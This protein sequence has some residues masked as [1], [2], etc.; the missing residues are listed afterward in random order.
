MLFKIVNRMLNI[1]H[2]YSVNT[3]EQNF[4]IANIMVDHA[5]LDRRR[6]SNFWDITVVFWDITVA[7]WDITVVFWDI[8]VVFW[9]ITGKSVC[10]VAFCMLYLLYSF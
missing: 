4:K 5:E 7:F 6:R 10:H 3:V 1:T 2:K 8:T 9:D